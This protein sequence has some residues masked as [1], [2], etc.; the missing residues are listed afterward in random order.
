MPTEIVGVYESLKIKGLLALLRAGRSVS[1]EGA[2]TI[3]IFT[4]GMERHR[5]ALAWSECEGGRFVVRA[6]TRSA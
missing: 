4:P 6:T 1:H 3:R 2:G 5:V